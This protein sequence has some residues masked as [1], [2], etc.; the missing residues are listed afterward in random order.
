M[1]MAY[2]AVTDDSG[3]SGGIWVHIPGHVNRDSRG[4]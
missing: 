1:Q 3:G 2:S 4:M